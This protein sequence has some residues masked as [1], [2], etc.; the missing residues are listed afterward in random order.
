MEMTQLQYF[1]TVARLEHFTRAA[2][3]LF[4]TQP[5]LSK[6]ISRLERELGVELFERDGSSVYLSEY[7]HVFLRQ[8]DRMFESLDDAK[9]EISDMKLGESGT[10]AFAID[11][12][13]LVSNPLR[14][15]VASHPNIHIRQIECNADHM[16]E[17]L[18]NREVDLAVSTV[19]IEGIDFNWNH[20][21][22]RRLGILASAD[23]RLAGKKSVQLSDL[24][25]EHFLI[26]NSNDNLYM[27]FIKYCEEEGF[28]PQIHFE[29][30]QREVVDELIR[31]NRGISVAGR[32]DIFR[33]TPSGDEEE[34]I[35]YIDIDKPVCMHSVG[36]AT[37]RGR[38]L[39]LSAID[40]CE[41]L[42]KDLLDNQ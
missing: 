31:D 42:K 4:I 22:E 23:H 9:R 15:Y 16:R 14:S 29:G 27:T 33:I 19:P 37:L 34:K 39:P 7:G 13:P 24:S 21:T 3:E 20:L 28:I 10:L 36:I 1:R 25:N 30:N 5:T 18:K 8:V 35:I 6:T 41:C 2:N 12:P 38:Y 11:L 32:H 17:M 40:F 26:N